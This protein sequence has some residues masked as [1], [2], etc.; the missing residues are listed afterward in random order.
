M[1][2]IDLL[3]NTGI[4]P[5]KA[6]GTSGGEYHSP[7]PGCGGT[8]RFCAWP[9]QNGGKG[10]YWCRQCGKGGDSIQFLIDFKGLNFKQACEQLGQALPTPAGPCA[11]KFS[12][13]KKSN[14]SWQPQPCGHTPPA[15]WVDKAEALVAWGHERLLSDRK[16]LNW[17]KK[18]G[19]TKETTIKYRL[20]WNPGKNGKDFFRPREYWGLP[21][22]LKKNGAKKRLWIPRGLIIPY[23][24][25][26][27]VHR[28]RIRRPEG[29]PRYYVLPGSKMDMLTLQPERRALV[30]LESELDAILV[31]QEAGSLCG[32]VA[33]G[34]S[35]AKPSCDVAEALR[36]AAII[37]LALNYDGAG[38]KA[39][40]WWQEHFDRVKP[41]SV[42]VGKDPGEAFTAGVDLKAWVQA[43][44]PEGWFLP[45]SLL[46]ARKIV[47]ES[48]STEPV[49]DAGSIP[50]KLYELRDLLQAHPVSIF[51]SPNQ[52]SL[53]E[54]RRWARENWEI[55]KK[56][57]NLVFMEPE[58]FNYIDSHPAEIITG[59]NI[60]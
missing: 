17:L 51:A 4:E 36:T 10:S 5:K 3:R 37:L 54:G 11:P 40:V 31:D 49:T 59:D 1:N 12:T 42:P 25:K 9:E 22:E 21:T 60:I 44:L 30:V 41:W 39:I 14:Q 19:I 33:L 47:R 45:Q 28:I 26:G 2:V 52:V 20:G 57:S 24:S 48:I 56:I 34:S 23:F 15:P 7:C 29:E 58:V 8:D 35:S 32:C 38:E 46:G 27:E 53:R 6:A 55:S 50:E 16:I 18:R 13:S 43:G